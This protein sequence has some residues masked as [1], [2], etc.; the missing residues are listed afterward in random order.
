[1]PEE[2]LERPPSP[3]KMDHSITSILAKLKED[4]CE[5]PKEENDNTDDYEVI[6]KEGAVRRVSLKLVMD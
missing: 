4:G 6:L 1:M 3:V 5:V 2:P